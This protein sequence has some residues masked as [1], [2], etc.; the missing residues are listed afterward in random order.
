VYKGRAHL[1]GSFEQYSPYVRQEPP[2]QLFDVLL[3]KIPQLPSEFREGE[4]TW[5]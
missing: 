1:V 2:I 4:K 3:N 5:V